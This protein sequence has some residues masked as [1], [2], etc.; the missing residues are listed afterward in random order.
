MLFLQFLS[1]CPKQGGNVPLLK[2]IL[3]KSVGSTVFPE[4]TVHKCG[5]PYCPK[6]PDSS[7]LAI[8]RTQPPASYRFF[9]PSIGQM[10]DP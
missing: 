1:K 9:H 7:K 6:D 4:W 2:T 10:N 5:L 8:L 3:G